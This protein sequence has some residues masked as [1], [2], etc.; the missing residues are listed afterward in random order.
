[1]RGVPGPTARHV[2]WSGRYLGR[3]GKKAT[4]IT[5]RHQTVNA[6]SEDMGL[7]TDAHPDDL[8]QPGLP[9]TGGDGVTDPEV[10]SGIVSSVVFYLRALRPPPRREASNAEVVAGRDLFVDVG[11][12][13]CHVTTLRT[14]PSAIAPLD[15]VEFAPFTDMLLHDMGA[16]LDD[17]YTEGNATSS[18]W[19]TAPLWGI[20]LAARATGG[21]M[22]L[23]HDGRARS[24]RA[25]I[26]FHGGEA[27]ASRA[28]F[29]ALTVEE[30]ERLLRYLR[31]L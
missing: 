13:K 14:G 12:A 31:S 27:A 4:T 17:G 15:R 10:G 30:Q 23:L 26:G 1:M 5:L 24:L 9:G 8:L 18:E 22:F 6:Y 2:A 11:C 29:N 25:A 19:R 20:G 21:T 3:F 16:D 28:A 7:T